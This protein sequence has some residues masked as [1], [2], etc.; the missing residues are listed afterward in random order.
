MNENEWFLRSKREKLKELMKERRKNESP[1]QRQKRLNQMK[2]YAKHRRA[3]ESPEQR[4]K[5]LFQ[6]NMYA[7]Q[8]RANESLDQRIKRLSQMNNYEKQRRANETPE[9]R[10]ERKRRRREIESLRRNNESPEERQKRLIQMTKYAKERRAAQ[11]LQRSERQLSQI[12]SYVKQGGLSETL[13]KEE[14]QSRQQQK[15]GLQGTDEIDLQ[16]KWWRQRGERD[17]LR[18][19]D[20]TPM[21]HEEH[22]VQGGGGRQCKLQRT[23]ETVEQIQVDCI[24]N[25]GNWCREQDTEFALCKT[26]EPAEQYKDKYRREQEND[27]QRRTS[28][29]SDIHEEHCRQKEI[30]TPQRTNMPQE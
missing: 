1:E 21:A 3:N 27:A 12:N 15:E 10:E 11:S 13:E 16:E 29:T 18:R 26:N 22:R 24:Q 28:D 8:R 6:M 9:Q 14:D 7:R 17:A 5:R 30:F 25:Q 4:Q 19:T 20:K 23:Y 2:E